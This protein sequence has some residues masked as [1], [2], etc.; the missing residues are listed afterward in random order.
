M[1]NTYNIFKFVLGEQNDKKT[2]Y[3][4]NSAGI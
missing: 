1:L 2:T 4:C 3:L